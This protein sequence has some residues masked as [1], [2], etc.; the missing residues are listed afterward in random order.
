[1]ISDRKHSPTHRDRENKLYEKKRRILPEAAFFL[2]IVLCFLYFDFYLCQYALD[3]RRTVMENRHVSVS[4]A[5]L[6]PESA[7]EK[8]E[9]PSIP[10]NADTVSEESA[11]VFLHLS[12]YHPLTVDHT[13]LK[14]ENADYIGWIDIPETRISYPV[15]RCDSNFDYLHSDARH[16]YLYAGCIYRD[17][18]TEE[19]S[20]N[21]VLHGHN[22][23][24][25]TMFAGLNRYLTEGRDFF[26]KHR[27]I[28]YYPADG[29]IEVYSVYSVY[30]ASAAEAESFSFTPT[31]PGKDEYKKFLQSACERSIY[32]SGYTPDPSEKTLTLS[33]C[34]GTS[35]ENRRCIVHA[36]LVLKQNTS[37]ER[38]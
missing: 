29:G 27:M 18:N 32:S 31:F 30:T 23:R 10:E 3:D 20:Q 11:S 6:L 36:G 1:M 25:G 15:Y 12:G 16:N 17:A 9:D 8:H 5:I 24:S 35:R 13:A 19:D 26:T 28:V 38:K 7:E 2:L 4:E 22:M 14:E 33:T 37:A 21:T 34:T